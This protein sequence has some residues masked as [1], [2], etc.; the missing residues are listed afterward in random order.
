MG[1]KG[2]ELLDRL[3]EFVEDEVRSGS[4]DLTL[5]KS[6]TLGKAQVRDTE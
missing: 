1:L 6:L 3:K 2:A 4:M 5:S